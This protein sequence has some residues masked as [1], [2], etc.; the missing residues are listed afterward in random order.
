MFAKESKSVEFT[1]RLGKILEIWMTSIAQKFKILS[2]K[3]K[4]TVRG[5]ALDTISDT[6]QGF[7]VPRGKKNVWR[8]GYATLKTVNIVCVSGVC[9]Y[10]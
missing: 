2:V 6:K 7:I 5:S 9:V 10:Y 4:Q 1:R 8:M 3:E